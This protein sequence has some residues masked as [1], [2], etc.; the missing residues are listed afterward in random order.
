M[1]QLNCNT[2]YYSPY[3]CRAIISSVMAISRYN[4][5]NLCHLLL[6]SL[7]PAP[8]QYTYAVC[9]LDVFGGAKSQTGRQ[10]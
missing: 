3:S 7:L 2:V 6:V 9:F 5:F 1:F 8:H 4:P 10:S